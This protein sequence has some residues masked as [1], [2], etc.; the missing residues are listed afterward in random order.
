MRASI[1]E[2]A[3]AILNEPA[4][5]LDQTTTGAS[6]LLAHVVAR[7][8]EKDRDRRYQSLS[9]VRIELED[10]GASAARAAPGTASPDAALDRGARARRPDRARRHRELGAAIAVPR[11]RT[12]ARIQRARLDHRRRLQQHDRRR[13]VRPIASGRARGRD[14]PIPVRQC[15]SPGSCGGHAEADAASAAS[16][17]STRRSPPKWRNARTSAVSWPATS[18]NS[19]NTYS[20]TARLHSPA[21][22]GGRPDRVGH[23][24]GQGRHPRSA[25]RA[26]DARPQPP[27]RIRGGDGGSI[28]AVATRHHIV[29]RRA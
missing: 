19:G 3:N 11:D 26:R 15:V 17:L 5:L 29:A 18:R 9:D 6:P 12:G 7:C 22:A 16:P 28:Q 14:R 10:P 13:R 8:L 4:P 23:G 2:T 24:R 25:G 21:D 20:L 1:F 27:W